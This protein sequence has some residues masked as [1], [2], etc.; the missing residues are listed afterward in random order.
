MARTTREQL[1]HREGLREVV[2]P[3]RPRDQARGRHSASRAVRDEDGDGALAPQLAADLDARDARQPDIQHQ[4]VEPAGASRGERLLPALDGLDLVAFAAQRIREGVRERR[5]VL[6]DQDP[7]RSPVHD[8]RRGEAQPNSC[9]V[10]GDR[11][12]LNG[13]AEGT[14]DLP[15]DREPETE[16]AR[17]ACRRR[18]RNDRTPASGRTSLMPGPVSR[19]SISPETSEVAARERRSRPRSCSGGVEGEFRIAW[20]RR[21]R[22]AN[23]RETLS[24]EI[25][26]ATPSPRSSSPR[27]PPAAARRPRGAWW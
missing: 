18:G 6:D 4:H 22:S 5:L 21:S 14:D 2:V 11:I 10:S 1:T 25:R 26:R 13:A 15:R 19:T 17:L 16:A 9:P 12:E 8:P 3:R 23:Y 24:H 27:S 7:R 20:R